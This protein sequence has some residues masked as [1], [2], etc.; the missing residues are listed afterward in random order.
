MTSIENFGGR[1][2]GAEAVPGID[3]ATGGKGGSLPPPLIG[4]PLRSIQIRGDFG[5]GKIG[6]KLSAPRQIFELKF[7]GPFSPSVNFL[8]NTLRVFQ[9]PANYS[10][11]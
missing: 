4:D 10:C 5:V 11:L 6:G 1:G 9:S 3:V 2:V 7:P 8:Q